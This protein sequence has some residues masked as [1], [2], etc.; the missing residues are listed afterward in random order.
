MEKVKTMEN[1]KPAAGT[2]EEAQAK[3]DRVERRKKRLAREEAANKI[4]VILPTDV[5]KFISSQAQVAGLEMGHFMQRIVDAY[6]LETAPKDEPMT[7]TVAARRG[8]VDHVVALAQSK[9]AAGEV[10]EH[11][12]LNVLK[13]AMTDAEFVK[14]YD[15][16]IAKAEDNEKRSARLRTS[17]NQQLGRMVKRAAGL[18]SKR[19]AKGKIMRA[20]VQDEL[21]STYT[22]VDPAST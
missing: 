4:T 16:A 21:L 1:A 15:V 3:K 13:D 8:V 19:D 10:D 20:Q 12:V 7:M 18:K 14:M 11:F 9:V 6:V 22:L 5:R 2:T 17:L